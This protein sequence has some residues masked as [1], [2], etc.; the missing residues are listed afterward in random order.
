MWD[1]IPSGTPS[2]GRNFGSIRFLLMVR[3][4]PRKSPAFGEAILLRTEHDLRLNV[5]SRLL[6][7]YRVQTPRTGPNRHTYPRRLT[8]RASL[9][10]PGPARSPDGHGIRAGLTRR[11]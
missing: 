9:I 8:S 10:S 11:L 6:P 7:R 4:P 1:R 2:T 5:T 3:T